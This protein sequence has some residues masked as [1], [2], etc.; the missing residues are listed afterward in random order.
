MHA[1][2]NTR[3]RAHTHTHARTQTYTYAQTRTQTHTQAHTRKHTHTH[4]H[5]HTHPYDQWSSWPGPV[6]L[7]PPGAAERGSARRDPGG[8]G[9]GA[10]GTELQDD[11]QPGLL[12]ALGGGHAGARGTHARSEHRAGPSGPGQAAGQP[13]QDQRRLPDG[14]SLRP[15]SGPVSLSLLVPLVWVNWVQLSLTV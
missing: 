4:T 9:G 5:T 1:F 6:H 10:A 14:Q 3:A 12:P 8:S 11:R 13:R 15:L 7:Q 2:T